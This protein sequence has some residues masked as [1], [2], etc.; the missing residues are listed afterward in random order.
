MVEIDNAILYD[1]R[2]LQDVPIVGN[3]GMGVSKELLQPTPLI[4]SKRWSGHLLNPVDIPAVLK[5]LGSSKRVR[6]AG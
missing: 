5:D 1:V 4:A 3:S 6:D 2:L